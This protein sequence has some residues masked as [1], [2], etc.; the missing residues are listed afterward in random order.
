VKYTVKNVKRKQACL[1]NNL[2]AIQLLY[3]VKSM[4]AYITTTFGPKNNPWIE[5]CQAG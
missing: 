2:K 3:D 1:N 4:T 5:I